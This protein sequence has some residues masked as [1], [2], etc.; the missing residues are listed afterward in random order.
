M[1]IPRKRTRMS[2]K[3]NAGSMADIAF[4]LLIFFLVTTTIVEDTGLMVRLPPWEDNPPEKE[5]ASR[6]VFKILV[7]A[8]NNI[9]ARKEEVELTQLKE[10]IKVF[11]SNPSNDKNLASRPEKAIVSL[12]NDRSTAYKT[13][14]S[15][16]NE[17][18]MAYNELRNE[19]A[20]KDY[21]KS[22]SNCSSSE[23]LAIKKAIPLVISEAEPTD[24]SSG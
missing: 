14:V 13:Y 5:M 15:V 9:F 10:R 6:N 4:L 20:K 23:K 16:Y 19:K 1:K 11:I 18:K 21:G 3:V 22:Y 8:D 12:Q 2:N 17:I 7:N 24:Y